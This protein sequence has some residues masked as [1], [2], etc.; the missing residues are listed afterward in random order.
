VGYLSRQ[1]ALV[2][3]SK[4]TKRIRNYGIIGL[5]STRGTLSG[6]NILGILTWP[7]RLSVGLGRSLLV[8]R[9]MGWIT[10]VVRLLGALWEVGVS[11]G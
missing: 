9:R 10:R 1:S 5:L 6:W 7:T 3:R 4:S 8:T 11:R 2:A